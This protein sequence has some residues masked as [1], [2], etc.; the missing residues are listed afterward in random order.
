[1]HNFLLRRL[2]L[3]RQAG[4]P[5]RDFLAAFE[6]QPSQESINLLDANW[7]RSQITKVING[8]KEGD[9]G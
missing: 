4:Q 8:S 1:L 3:I 5:L 6:T 7:L 2:E 9:N